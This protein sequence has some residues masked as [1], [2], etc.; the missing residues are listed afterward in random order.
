MPVPHQKPVARV[1]DRDRLVR[2]FAVV[3]RP[4]REQVPV[5]VHSIEQA[6]AAARGIGRFE[7]PEV[8][9]VLDA[10]T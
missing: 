8:G 9:S 5:V 7:K 10:P 6:S 3:E 2:A 1:G 4:P